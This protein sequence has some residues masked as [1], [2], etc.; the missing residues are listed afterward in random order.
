[1]GYSHPLRVVASLFHA[2]KNRGP[3]FLR[4]FLSRP[5]EN[6][7][8]QRSGRESEVINRREKERRGAEGRRRV[9]GGREN[10]CRRDKSI[11][12]IPAEVEWDC[13]GG[14]D[15]VGRKGKRKVWSTAPTFSALVWSRIITTNRRVSCFPIPS[16]NTRILVRVHTGTHRREKEDNSRIIRCPIDFLY[17]VIFIRLYIRTIFDIIRG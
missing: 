11:K 3:L 10:R 1:M 8:K 5:N 15:V 4:R 17:F 7:T 13:G 9:V 12:H 2:A 6:A 14:S 16:N